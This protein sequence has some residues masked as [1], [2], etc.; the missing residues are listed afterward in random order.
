MLHMDLDHI[1]GVAVIG[2]DRRLEGD[3][4]KRSIA[5]PFAETLAALAWANA[6]IVEGIVPAGILGKG[7]GIRI[8]MVG[9]DS[10]DRV[11]F[12]LVEIEAHAG[13]RGSY[14]MAQIVRRN[15]DTLAG[16]LQHL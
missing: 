9:L 4:A 7:R 8:E 10:A 2:Q 6:E 13:Q 3:A 11:T 14:D 15:A 1:I 5:A 12:R 16:F